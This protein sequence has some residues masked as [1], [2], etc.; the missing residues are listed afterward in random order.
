M[1]SIMQ[2]AKNAY[3][4]LPSAFAW[5][6]EAAQLNYLIFI[7]LLCSDNYKLNYLLLL[8]LFILVTW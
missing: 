6:I 4:L 7:D 8:S 3:S 2:S 1:R 5:W